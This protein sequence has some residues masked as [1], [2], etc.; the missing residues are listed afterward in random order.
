MEVGEQ[1]GW[2]V[3]VASRFYKAGDPV[4]VFV[5]TFDDPKD[6]E[7]AVSDARHCLGETYDAVGTVA[8]ERCISWG[9][10]PA[11]VQMI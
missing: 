9:I 11:T 5:A 2:L 8:Y 3:L 10:P 7:L 6:A 4:R 1:G